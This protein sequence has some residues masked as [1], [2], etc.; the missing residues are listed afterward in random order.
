MDLYDPENPRM[1]ET[2]GF[3]ELVPSVAYHLN[4]DLRHGDLLLSVNADFVG[5]VMS[6]C[7]RIFCQSKVK[8]GIISVQTHCRD[9]IGHL[10]IVHSKAHKFI[11]IADDEFQIDHSVY[12]KDY[13]NYRRERYG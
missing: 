12:K 2:F 5:R 3:F 4:R 11:P 7:D 13:R 1:G 6:V 10:V 9:V 8:S